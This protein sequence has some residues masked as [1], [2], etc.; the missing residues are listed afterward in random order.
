MRVL[1]Q[2]LHSLNAG[3]LTVEYLRNVF[4]VHIHNVTETL[5]SHDC[6]SVI[7]FRT[8]VFTEG[9]KETIVITF[10]SLRK[11]EITQSRCL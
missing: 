11:E 5:F 2:Y 9:Y 3:K 8:E 7:C 6:N 1:R 4:L 10:N